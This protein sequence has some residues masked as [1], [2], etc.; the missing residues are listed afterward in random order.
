MRNA[1]ARS[2]VVASAALLSFSTATVA[3]ATPTLSPPA[4][5][6]QVTTAPTLPRPTPS[7]TTVSGLPFGVA[8]TPDGR[9]ALVGQGPGNVGNPDLDVLAIGRAGTTVLRTV[10]LPG[11][12]HATGVALSR[13]GRYLAVGLQPPTGEPLG[14]T[15]ILSVRALITGQGDPV[16]ATLNDGT[17]GQIEE[18]FSA[19]GR[20]VFVSDEYSTAV[21]VFDLS[22][23]LAHGSTAPGVD[24]GQIPVSPGPV[25]LV[26]SPDGQRLYLTSEA[27]WATPTTVNPNVGE[28]SVLDVHTAEHDPAKAVL[29][30]V[31]A[32]CDPV[33]VALSDNGRLAWVT[34][35]GSDALLA[36]D[37]HAVA[38][39]PARALLADVPVGAQP[40]G[41][42]TVS[43]GRYVLVANS[44]RF[45]AP[46]AA[47]SVSVVD[48]AAALAGKPAQLGLVPAGQ[49]PRELAYDPARDL[50]LLSNFLSQSV[51]TFAVPF[52]R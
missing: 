37:I 4:C 9:Y 50:V 22:V 44:A 29:A 15:D 36:F 2:A 34:A 28:L 23:A 46:N 35:R 38:H 47:Q 26:A 5:T 1:L 42:L 3:S 30:T 10:V 24:V 33:R 16:L 45:T 40:V 43:G 39:D 12:Y 7:Y 41:V 19:D 13:D 18:A 31:D 21:S 52:S 49:F 20:Y 27:S 14:Y 8:V 17:L 51:E 25:G 6:D 48:A 32:G 11:D